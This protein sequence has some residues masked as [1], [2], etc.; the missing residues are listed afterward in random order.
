LASYGEKSFQI[1]AIYEL[2]G[3]KSSATLS[4]EALQSLRLFFCKFCQNKTEKSILEKGIPLLEE[5]FDIVH[6]FEQIK[7]NSV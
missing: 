6:I 4:S 1:N 7:K 5:D 3:I 2:Y